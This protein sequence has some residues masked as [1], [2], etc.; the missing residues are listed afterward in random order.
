MSFQMLGLNADEPKGTLDSACSNWRACCGVGCVGSDDPTCRGSGVRA[1]DC[2]HG[3]RRSSRA[4]GNSPNGCFGRF[5]S[6]LALEPKHFGAMAGQAIIRMRQGRMRAA[7]SILRR[8][9]EI[10]P[11]LAER[12][13]IVPRPGEVEPRPGERRL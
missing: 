3:A 6:V 13:M 9:V 12:A 2:R 8:A 4:P 10:H 11:F 5:A 7:Q 1:G